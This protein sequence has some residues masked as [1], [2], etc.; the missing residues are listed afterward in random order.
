MSIPTVTGEQRRAA[1]LQYVKD[2][3][4]VEGFAPTIRDIQRGLGYASP[5]SAAHQIDLLVEEGLLVRSPG[6]PRTLRAVE[7]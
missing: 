5:S 7:P 1:I 3:W 2:Y 4:T 6:R